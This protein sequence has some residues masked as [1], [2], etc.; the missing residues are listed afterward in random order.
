MTVS[1][2][3]FNKHWPEMKFSKNM[4]QDA[5]I[6]HVLGLTNYHMADI[7]E[8]FEVTVNLKH[9]NEENWINSWST[10]AN[11]L[12]KRRKTTKQRIKRLMRQVLISV[13]QPTGEY[14]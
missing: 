10:M 6:K 7:G 1:N 3:G 8:V 11:R 5:L 9:G 12:Q 2:E 13:L 4:L 14:L